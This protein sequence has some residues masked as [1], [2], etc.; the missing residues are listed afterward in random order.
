MSLRRFLAAAAL[1]LAAAGC[2]P[3]GTAVPPSATPPPPTASPTASPTATVVWFPP[4][5]TPAPP[6]AAEPS[7]TVFPLPERG[8]LLISDDFSDGSLWTLLAGTRGSAALGVNELTI[9]INEPGYYLSAN[10]VDLYLTDFYLEFTAATSLCAG[11]DEYGV[12][13]RA[14]SPADFYRLSLSCDGRLRLD[15]IRGGTA[16]SPLP[17]MDSAAVPRNAPASVRIG[18]WADG[19]QM[20]I[21]LNDAYQVSV[22]TSLIP[23]GTLGFFARSAGTNAV[24][25]NFR[26][27]SVWAVSQGQAP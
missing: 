4:T 2:L 15:L 23:G 16:S 22:S 21:Y 27:L 26:A 13:L 12:L 25:V 17:W 20:H 24:T 6:A 8:E 18:V 7:P 1:I 11:P 10:R 19:S 5:A 3:A 9:V 14:A